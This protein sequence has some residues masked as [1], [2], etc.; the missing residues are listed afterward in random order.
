M[1]GSNST[2]NQSVST[3]IVNK[4]Y[5]DTLNKTVM[6]S[7]VSTMINNAST[8][9]SAVNQN[10]S[11]D[12]SGT[13]V[14]GD[15]NFSGNQSNKAKVDF[16]CIQ[17]STTSTAMATEM[18][19]AMVAEMKSLSGSEAAA[20]LNNAAAASNKNG[21]GSIGGGANST[22]NTNSNTNV[23][24]DTI[25]HVENIFQ[26]NLSNSFTANTVNECIGK[27][28][29]S[30]SQNLSN[31][32]IKGNAKVECFQ[33]NTLEQVQECKQLNEAINTTTQ[34]VLQELGLKVSTENTT[35]A[36]TEA[37]SS[38]TSENVSTGPIQ[39]LGNAVSGI[40]GSVSGL[41]GSV[42]GL[43]SLAM[44][45]PILGPICSIC[46]C[47]ICICLIIIIGKSVMG[48]GGGGSGSTS[49]ISSGISNGI[50]NG[51][52]SGSMDMSSMSG[53]SDMPVSM[54]TVPAV[55][56]PS[57]SNLQSF[58]GGF[59]MYNQIAFSDSSF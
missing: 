26:Q 41:V 27:T 3:N 22:T 2:S 12:M 39:D 32:N 42:S 33:A 55:S 9:S 48:G 44:L 36:T 25:A 43:A 13:T 49:G 24:N 52:S 45:G 18:G 59:K 53:M 23:T 20:N 40:I 29:Q 30:N 8:C 17:A 14:G 46:C 16:S 11:C 34:K 19:A 35:K 51:I 10:N 38:A 58:S 57:Y 5:M 28:T 15:F 56:A 54:G 37:K 21:F 1:G 47:I 50:S 6:E 7:A 4:S 31:M